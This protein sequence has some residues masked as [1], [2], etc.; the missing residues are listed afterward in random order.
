MICTRHIQVLPYAD[1]R[2]KYYLLESGVRDVSV[3]Y[4]ILIFSLDVL[5]LSTWFCGYRRLQ[6]CSHC[7]VLGD[8]TTL[9][10]PKR[11]DSVASCKSLTCHQVQT[12]MFNGKL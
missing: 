3:L 8:L 12:G 4:L 5:F 2:N 1:L 6:R 9:C 11:A 7:C 10:S